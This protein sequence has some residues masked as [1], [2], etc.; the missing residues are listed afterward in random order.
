M[1]KITR[2]VSAVLSTALL[3]SVVTVAPFSVS[4]A[5]IQN[6]DEANTTTFESDVEF[7]VNGTDSTESQEN[8]NI[9]SDTTALLDNTFEL[10]QGGKNVQPVGESI[11]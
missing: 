3:A 11:I 5:E 7:V 6:N 9:S 10:T 2:I 4:A 8:T 1:K